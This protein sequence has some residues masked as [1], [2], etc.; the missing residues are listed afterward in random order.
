MI[1]SRYV[2]PVSLLLILSLLPTIIHS[3]LG[4]IYDDGRSVQTI[5]TTLAG[6]SSEPYL[7][8]KDQWVKSLYGSED[9]I[10]RIYK[11]DNGEKIRLFAARSYDY[12]KLY[13]HPE[14]G[15]SHGSNLEE[16]GIVMLQGDP[17]IPVFVL[18]NNSGRGIVAYVLLHEG[19]FVKNPVSH[20]INGA[21]LQLFSPMKAMTLFYVSDTSSTASEIFN[22]TS[23]A[24]LLAAAI[25]SYKANEA[26][27]K[28]N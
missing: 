19:K 20:Q 24:S 27:G 12:K 9:W 3:Y 6:F 23:S 14:L 10:E 2:I 21:F 4:S 25:Q 28:V 8:H 1:S 26:A 22:R 16:E 17:E 11:N 7:R 15:L 5:P 18:R 13:H